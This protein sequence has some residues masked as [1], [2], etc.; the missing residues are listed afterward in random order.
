MLAW[1]GCGWGPAGWQEQ[2]A[3]Q[4]KPLASLMIVG[5][6]SHLRQIGPSLQGCWLS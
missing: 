2:A 5:Q 6:S 1:Q 3:Q 4:L